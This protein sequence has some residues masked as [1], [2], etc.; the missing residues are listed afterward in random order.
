M[1]QVQSLHGVSNTSYV[2]INRALSLK[3]NKV[4]TIQIHRMLL[5]IFI[6][7]LLDGIFFPIQIHRMLLLIIDNQDR[8]VLET[9]IQIHRMLLL[10]T[11]PE[12]SARRLSTIQIHRMLLL[13]I[14][15]TH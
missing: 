5:L 15:G 3:S 1:K 14:A 12:R 13:I 8:L 6:E 9:K 10:I 2:A 4:R 7:L 11:L